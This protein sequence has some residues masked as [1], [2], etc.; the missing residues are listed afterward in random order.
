MNREAVRL[1]LIKD[2]NM[3]NIRAKMVLRNL[4]SEQ[5]IRRKEICSGLSAR[6]LEEPNLLGKVS[7]DDETCIF[8]YNTETKFTGSKINRA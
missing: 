7:A 4:S 6:L 8:Q 5:E 2:L 1:F 3:K